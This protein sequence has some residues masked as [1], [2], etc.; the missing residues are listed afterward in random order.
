MSDEDELRVCEIARRGRLI[1]AEPWFEGGQP[2]VVQTRGSAE[3]DD[4][5]LALLRIPRHGRARVVEL[6]GPSAEIESV[7]K[8]LLLDRGARWTGEEAARAS[9]EAARLGVEPSEHEGRVDLRELPSVTIDP[10]GARD[11]DDAISVQEEGGGR[12]VW[13][14]I[15]D[16]SAYVRPGTALDRWAQERAFSTY[17]PGQVSPMLPEA[18]SV[19]ACSLRPGRDRWCVTV[20]FLVGDDATASDVSMYRSV[21][22]SDARLTYAEAELIAGGRDAGVDPAVASIVREA[23]AVAGRL[24]ERRFGRGAMRLERPELVIALDGEGG[25]ESASWEH[26]P[27]AHAL[28]EELMILANETVAGFLAGCRAETLYRIHP[29]P[30]PQ[31]IVGLIERLAALDVPTPPQPERLTRAGAARLAS[32][33]AGRVAAHVRSRPGAEAF[34]ALVLRSLEQASY[35]PKNGGHSGLAS[36]AYCHFTSPIRRYPDVVAHRVLLAQ[37]GLDERPGDPDLDAI[38]AHTSERERELAS[39]EHQANDIC[40]AW[41]LDRVLYEE[42]WE[43]AF[44]GEITGVIASGLFVRFG[45]VFEGYLPVRALQ[46]DYFELDEHGVS[47]V[48]RRGGRRYRLGGA[49]DVVV[50]ALDQ[51]D[52]RV[53][54]ALSGKNGRT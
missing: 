26:E 31:A 22:R 37:L 21:I 9:T 15:A 17:V 35:H 18:L 34:T 25:V 46:G 2:V 42:G 24:R 16:V 30:D 29:E 6:I 41:L 14:H 1:V 13:V 32:E 36:R 8:G 40:L 51:S 48:G 38:A 12:R 43:A 27:A 11:F 39:I 20:E 23:A 5:E 4:G 47:L 28:I 53:K 45:E 50:D 19:G 3:P 54:L 52:G 49:V 44:E 33:I 7:L 10:E